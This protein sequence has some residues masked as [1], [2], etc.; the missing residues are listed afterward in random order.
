MS[1]LAVTL[2][3][4]SSHRLP[5]AMIG[6]TAMAAHGV[7]RATMDIDLL[8]VGRECLES[9]AWRELREQGIE[10]DIHRGDHDDPLVGVVH[11]RQAGSSPIDVIVGGSAWQRRA[12][13]RATTVELFG[14]LVPLAA[15][16]DLILLKL[17]AGAPQDC[18]DVSRL[19]EASDKSLAHEVTDEIDVLPDEAQALWRTL[20]RQAAGQPAEE[21]V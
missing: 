8:L 12:V 18:W 16:R 20:H 19:L 14:T 9:H 7:A 10:V 15:A 6:A 21:E 1:L 2:Q 17:Y 5:C 3:A 13:E 11:L 4:L